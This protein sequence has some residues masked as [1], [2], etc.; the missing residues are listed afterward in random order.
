VV[1]YHPGNRL[2]PSRDPG[3]YNKKERINFHK[4]PVLVQDVIKEWCAETKMALL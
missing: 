3:K 1:L 2:A 4:G